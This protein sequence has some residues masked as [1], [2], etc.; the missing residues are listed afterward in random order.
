MAEL[1]FD[2]RYRADTGFKNRV[3]G[4]LMEAIFAMAG[5]DAEALCKR[6]EAGDR[7]L[8]LAEVVAMPEPVAELELTAPEEAAEDEVAPEP[9]RRGRPPGKK[10][11]T[12]L[13]TKK[14]DAEEGD[15]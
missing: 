1:S 14:A 10:T 3:D 12:R 13:T 7:E 4:I 6:W 8:R 15:G 9:K 11:T 5:I 2:Q